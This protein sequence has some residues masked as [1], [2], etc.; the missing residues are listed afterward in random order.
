MADEPEVPEDLHLVESFTNSVDVDSAQDDLDSPARFGR[1]LTAHG[2]PGAPP[3]PAELDLARA[4]RAALRDDLA[5]HD[6]HAGAHDP[7]DARARLDELAGQ[8]PL[9]VT[10][11][12]AAGPAAGSAAGSA[13]GFAPAPGLRGAH[14]MLAQVL[15]AVV[16]AERAGTWH[17]LK[18]CRA[19]D[20][21]VVYFDRSKNT[22]KAWCSM[23]GCGNR[24]KTRAYRG[25][26]SSQG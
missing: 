13:A 24:A 2:F 6:R 19:D 3:G 8:L 12:P 21:Q 4:V 16:L 26:R 10:F 17:R 18:L 14:A 22:S 7:G 5:G 15:A 20:C 9:R 1:W 23:E 25:R 11:G